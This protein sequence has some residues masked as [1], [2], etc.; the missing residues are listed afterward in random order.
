MRP[1]P[2]RLGSDDAFVDTRSEAEKKAAE[3]LARKSRLAEAKLRN[4]PA[5]QAGW[6]AGRE[7]AASVDLGGIKT[8]GRIGND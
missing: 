2:A 8:S 5:G 1:Q 3:R 4:S 6:K 7:A